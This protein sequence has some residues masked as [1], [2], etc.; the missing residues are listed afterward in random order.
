MA[1]IADTSVSTNDVEMQPVMKDKISIK[2]AALK[3][4]L[5]ETFP[6][7]IDYDTMV[8]AIVLAV[9]IISADRKTP[10][11]Q[12]KKLV[13]QAIHLLVD[14]TD[15]GALEILD[16]VIK[17]MAPTLVDNLIDVEKGKIRLNK[18]GSCLWKYL[19]CCFHCCC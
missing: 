16:P 17:S 12:K 7:G 11:Q 2:A 10:G 1:T 13:V 3:D 4:D 18:R 8:D 15:A 6:N 9:K 5:K 19:C 14:E